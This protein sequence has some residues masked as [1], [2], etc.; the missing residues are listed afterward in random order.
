MRNV[1]R[2]LNIRKYRTGQTTLLQPGNEPPL[3]TRASPLV[4]SIGDLE[5]LTPYLQL[6]VGLKRRTRR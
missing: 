1:S 3:S 4:A 6:G 5:A 2:A